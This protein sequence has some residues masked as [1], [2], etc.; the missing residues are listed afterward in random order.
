MK[1]L[2][3]LAA[4]L[5]LGKMLHRGQPTQGPRPKRR[6]KRIDGLLHEQNPVGF[7]W[8]EVG[9]DPKEPYWVRRL[10]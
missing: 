4:L 1:K 6:F 8:R 2:L 9:S 10:D 7:G 5:A 3:M